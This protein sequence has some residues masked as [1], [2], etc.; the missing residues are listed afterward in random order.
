MGSLRSAISVILISTLVGCGAHL[1]PDVVD[2]AIPSGY[3]TI[4]ISACDNFSYGSGYCYADKGTPLSHLKIAFQTYYAGKI[5]IDGCGINIS[6]RYLN[7]EVIQVDDS[8]PVKTDCVMT[9]T[10]SP[11]Y[12]KQT[13]SPVHIGGL[14]GHF[15]VFAKDQSYD[16]YYQINQVPLAGAGYPTFTMPL[17]GEFEANV[18]IVGTGEGC[19]IKYNQHFSAPDSN[20]ELPLEKIFPGSIVTN[21]VLRGQVSTPSADFRF[22]WVLNYYST[23]FVRLSEPAIQWSS[24]TKLCITSDENTSIINVAGKYVINTNGCFKIKKT[25]S[26]IIRAL[27]VGGRSAIGFWDPALQAVKWYR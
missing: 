12:P 13:S 26:F 7:S 3:D 5:V 6:K 2:Y 8:T 19:T 27:T 10:I 25:D 4:E 24:D 1:R 9:V 16:S 21:C 23:K 20:L 17:S 22:I 15:Y 18:T 14:R 11:D